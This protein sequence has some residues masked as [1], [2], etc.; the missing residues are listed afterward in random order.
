M[1]RFRLRGSPGK[2]NT[3]PYS[4]YVIPERYPYLFSAEISFGSATSIQSGFDKTD[5]CTVQ[6]YAIYFFTLLAR[7]WARHVVIFFRISFLT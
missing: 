3:P 7:F 2:P 5:R 1:Y 4:F 6:Q